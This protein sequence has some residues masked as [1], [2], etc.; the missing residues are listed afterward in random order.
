MVVSDAGHGIARVAAA[1]GRDSKGGAF[2]RTPRRAP[3]A[4]RSSNQYPNHLQKVLSPVNALDIPLE[5]KWYPR[6]T[7]EATTRPFC[8]H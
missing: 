3:I 8:S 6:L 5:V 1:G 2:T 7:W 4:F